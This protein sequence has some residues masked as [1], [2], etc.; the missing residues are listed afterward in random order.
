MRVLTWNVWWRFGPWQERRKALLS[1]LREEAPD[2]V[3]L[4]EVWDHDGENLAGWLADELGLHWAFAAHDRPHYWQR[5]IGG[6]PVAIGNAVLSRYPILSTESRLLPAPADRDQGRRALFARLDGPVA[7]VPFFTVHLNSAVHE[8]GTRVEQV[9]ELARFVAEHRADG[10]H[11]AVVSGDFNARPDSDEVRLF[12][13]SRTAPVVPRQSFVDAWD[14]AE[15]GA[16]WATWGDG[17]PYLASVPP[18]NAR[19]DYIHVSLPARGGLGHV[20]AVR[21]TGHGYVDGVWPSDHAA[22]VADLAEGPAEG[23]R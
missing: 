16:A 17:N 3:G 2:V 8:S 11:P 20:R 14:F 6:E 10:D 1:V 21:R 4:Q 19:I 15:E 13:G 5:R 23:L 9:A 12:G 7:P 18:P 22:V